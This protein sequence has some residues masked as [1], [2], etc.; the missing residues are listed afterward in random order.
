MVAVGM[1]FTVRRFVVG[2]VLGVTLAGLNR[3]SA[4]DAV[5]PTKAPPQE[6]HPGYDWT[7]FYAGGHIGYAAGSSTWS[8]TQAGGANLSGSLDLFNPYD[9]FQGTGSYLFGFQAGYNYMLASRL[10]LG[11]EADISFPS[12]YAGSQTFSS[13]LV[14][15]ASYRD[16]VELSGGLRAR[17]GYAPGNWLLYATGGFTY[18][19]DN[20]TRTQISGVPVG[21]TAQ[22]GDVETILMVPRVGG[23]VGGG[24][25]AAL[26]PRWTARLEFLYTDYASRGV[27]FPDA[28]Q[29]FTSDLKAQ[30]LRVGLDYRLGSDGTIDPEIFTKGPS[31]LETDNSAVHGQTT[32]LEQYAPPFRS[33]YVGPN[34]LTPNQGRETWDVTAYLG[35][36]LW[37]GAELWVDP[38]LDQG[39]GV[40]GT[41]GVAGFTSGEA[42]KVGAVIPYARVQRAFIRQT[43]DLGGETQKVE[44][45]AN[46]FSGSQT[47]NRLVLTVGR[48]AVTDVFDTNKYAHDPRADFM[49]W[50]LIDTATFDY[51]ADPWGYTYG[52]AAEWYWGNW[53]L[54]GGAFDLSI[55]PNDI[56]LDPNFAQ[57][58]WVGE[59]ERRYDL[60]GHPGKIAVTGFL[61]RGRMGTFADAI[62]LAQAAG[63]PADIAAVRQYRSR[64]GLSVNLEQEITPDLGVFMRAGLA[65]GAVEP[66]EFTDVDR[67]VAAGM[68]VKGKSWG[69]PDDT[70]G[71]AGIVNGISSEHVAYLN[72][73]GLGILIGD[74]ILPHPGP[75]QIL[76]TYYAFPVLAMTMTLDYQFIV[77]PAYNTDRGP[78]SVLSAR[79]HAQF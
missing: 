68:S 25:E 59:I 30:T 7:G 33:P 36:R 5:L 48:F 11:A 23:T 66:Y 19:Y 15:T 50:A 6:A 52:A 62:A 57:F 60:W 42:Y 55:I 77:N 38:E 49:N 61:S 41:L 1:G 13:S 74:G 37:T 14:G 46:Q 26:S 44:A 21:G 17:L 75:E 45:A 18:S 10:V 63:A 78:V 2:I 43:I 76:E 4:A 35:W 32:F 53:T 28:A 73:G 54:R 12:V 27:T 20:L 58:Q 16:Q 51:A 71:L 65:N 31:S 34:S 22:P 56:E 67:T 39:F 29:H 69:R 40:S 24:I 8:A 64:G 79:M 3:A 47:A 9:L 70:F 72:D